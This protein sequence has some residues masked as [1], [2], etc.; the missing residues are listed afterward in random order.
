MQ[1][2]ASF[3]AAF[4]LAATPAFGFSVP[5]G[6][7]DGIYIVGRDAAGQEVHTRA[8]D[9]S[10]D[11]LA[12]RSIRGAPRMKR[13]GLDEIGCFDQPVMVANDVGSAVNALRDQIG[14]DGYNLG[15]HLGLYSI[16]GETVAYCCNNRSQGNTCFLSSQAESNALI[17]ARCGSSQ[18]GYAYDSGAHLTYGYQH[19]TYSWCPES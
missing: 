1:F 16:V 18:P 5:E 19:K 6:T 10:P 4:L 15:S 2:K 17:T 3:V 9:V 11:G 7:K 13:D 12:S 8:A 14:P